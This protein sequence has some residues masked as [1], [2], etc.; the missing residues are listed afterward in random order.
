MKAIILA[1]GSG[2]RL[3]PLSR[4]NYPKQFLRLGSEKSLLQHTVERLLQAFTPQ[5]II[6]VTNKEYKFQIL[7]ELKALGLNPASL[8]LL[9]EPVGRNTAPAIALSV[10]YCIET[11]GC[12][13]NETIFVFPADHIIKPQERIVNYISLANEFAQK[14]YVITFGIKPD[15]AETGY[16]YI[17]I[18]EPLISNPHKVYEVERFTEKPDKETAEKY[19][20]EGDYFWNS[21]MFAFT[22]NTILDEFSLHMPEIRKMLDLNLNKI[23]STFPQMPNISIDYAVMEKSQKVALIPLELYWNDV[24]S[25]DSLYD[26][27]EKD[28]NGNALTGDVIALNTKES[29]IVGNKRLI[30]TIGI[31][32]CIIIETDDALLIAQKGQT[33]KVKEVVEELK[34]RARKEADEHTT[35]HR[36]WGSYTV[37]EVGPRYKIKRIVITPGEKLSLQMHHHRSEHWVV[38]KGT[39]KVVIDDKE[40]YLHEN[41]SI[42]VPKSTTHS[43]ENPGKIPLEI[44]EVQIGEYVEEDDIVRFEDKYGRE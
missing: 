7:N 29:L 28:K 37:L 40:T 4:K 23:I 11:L 3:W 27:L 8:N 39:A 14:G 43:L 31:D 34:K 21:G 5:D 17:K 19:L 30:S 15:R 38:V 25:W 20:K 9:L 13:E 24:G 44:I 1:G 32:N 22:I 41:E 12:S 33:Q 35:T 26:I 6:I 16:G 18:A 36:P 42:Y 2:T 10:K